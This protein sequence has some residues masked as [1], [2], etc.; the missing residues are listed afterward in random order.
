MPGK[1]T[2]ALLVEDKV[3]DSK[4]LTIVM[5]P[6][7]TLL[8]AE[9]T[10]YNAMIMDLHDAQR[11]GTEVASRLAAVNAEMARAS[12]ALDSSA[13][14]A[15]VKANFAAFKK[16]FDAV[17][18]KFGVGGGAGGPGAGGPGAGGRGAG[19]GAAGAA[20]AGP[21]G[22]AAGAAAAQAA[23]QANALGRVGTVKGAIQGLW[24]MPSDALV[25]QATDAKAALTPAI[26]EANAVL[27]RVR[28]L[29]AA[30]AP[31]NV[32]LTVPPG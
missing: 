30:L 27:A 3:V 19:A 5:D 4:P 17:R 9:R 23:A 18:V 1:Y 29:S 11:R 16:D 7:V 22:G 6:E 26:T 12:A 21:G 20:G 10:R 24:E 25:K 15:A 8:G 32:K 2:V 13:A 31:H 28:A 14:P